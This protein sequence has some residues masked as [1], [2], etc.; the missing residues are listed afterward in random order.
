MLLL[1]TLHY[2]DPCTLFSQ[3]ICTRTLPTQHTGTPHLTTLHYWSNFWQHCTTLHYTTP[4]YTTLHYTTLHYTTLHY[5]TQHYTTLHY[6]TLHSLYILI[7][8]SF[9][10][11]EVRISEKKHFGHSHHVTSSFKWWRQCLCDDVI[12]SNP[13][14]LCWCDGVHLDC[15]MRRW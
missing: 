15:E 8:P 6:A 9:R 11:L 2:I 3:L 5:T 13:S 1:S 10:Y 7:V 4:H 12:K 14:A